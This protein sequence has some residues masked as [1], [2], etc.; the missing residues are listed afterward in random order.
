MPIHFSYPFPIPRELFSAIAC[1]TSMFLFVCGQLSLVEVAYLS[2]GE[3]LWGKGN[4]PVV[5]PLRKMTLPSQ[6]PILIIV[7][8]GEMASHF[9]HDELLMVPT[10]CRS[11]EDNG[12]CSELSAKGCHV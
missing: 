9:I 8:Q 4:L 7:L 6:Q 2:V 1:F 10:L 5:T 11:F 3:R 12:S